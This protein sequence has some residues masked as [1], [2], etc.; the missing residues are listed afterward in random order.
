MIVG[1]QSDVGRLRSVLLKHARAAFGSQAAIE[2]QWRGLRYAQ[3]PDYAR[4]GDEYDAFVDLLERLGV[5]VFLLPADDVGLD[6]IYPRDAGLVCDGGI[7]AGRM[8]KPGRSAEPAALEKACLDLGVPLLGRV[9]EPGRL[10]GGDAAWLDPSTLVVGRGYR[11]DE[12][13][14]RQLRQLLG[15]RV[16]E[17]VEVPLPHW[18]GPDDVFHL[19]SVFSPLDVDLALVYSPLLP[20]PFRELLIER[21]FQLVE[22][23]EREFHTMAC[24]ALAVAPRRCVV[25][26]G[27]PATRARLEATEVEVHVYS[28][29]E[30][31]VK[32]AGG[33]TCLTLPLRRDPPP[34]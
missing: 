12:E 1:G 3:A 16:D 13:G 4:A 5:E 26:D 22:V 23:P 10:E 19:M 24:N 2:R 34:G 29:G 9:G 15:D 17:I 28:G 7:I 31:S 18:R 25:L 33:P 27:N 21:G 30:I 11:T 14:I 6:S 32:G 20:V 8:G